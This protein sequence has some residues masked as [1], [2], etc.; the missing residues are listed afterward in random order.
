MCQFVAGKRF[1]S[2]VMEQKA[3]TKEMKKVQPKRKKIKR[4]RS[5]LP[6]EGKMY[7]QE[8]SGKCQ[9]HGFRE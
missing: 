9:A 1:L 7:K 5:N 4:K 2:L 6:L 8:E 3:E